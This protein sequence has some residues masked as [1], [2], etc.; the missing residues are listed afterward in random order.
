MTDKEWDNKRTT[1]GVR[2][3]AD[4]R[5]HYKGI[6]WHNGVAFKFS[7]TRQVNGE[8]DYTGRV[9]V[10]SPESGKVLQLTGKARRQRINSYQRKHGNV[11]IDTPHCKQCAVFKDI[12][13]NGDNVDAVK[14]HIEETAKRLFA[15]N[16]VLL[17]SLLRSVCT[18]ET[19]T[20]S[21]AAQ[22]Y[23]EQFIAE[24]GKKI[25]QKTADAHI[26]RLT[27]ACAAL[28][29]RAMKVISQPEIAAA[30]KKDNISNR[31]QR[32]LNRF[33][34]YLLEKGL[35]TGVNPVPS[36]AQQKISTKLLQARAA[37]P[38]VLDLD[39]CDK[40][41]TLIMQHPPSGCD[42]G[43][44]L[45]LWGR[46]PPS[47]GLV[48]GDILFDPGDASLARMRITKSNN[49]G[50][51]HDYTRPLFPQAALILRDRYHSLQSRYKPKKLR[52]MPIISQDTNPAKAMGRNVVLQC[53]N[54]RLR[55]IGVKEETFRCWRAPKSAVSERIMFN[56]YDFLLQNNCGLADDPATVHFLQG[57]PLGDVTSD[58]YTSFTEPAAAKR[59][60]IAQMAVQPLMKI[61][62]PPANT[63]NG[64]ST[65]YFS[66][67]DTRST[68]A[69]DITLCIPPGG[70][71]SVECLNGVSLSAKPR[72]VQNGK[73][74]RKSTSKKGK[75]SQQAS[76]CQGT[77][78]NPGGAVKSAT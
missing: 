48:W 47:E 41:F 34:K 19:I 70:H 53:A 16:A 28:P 32:L 44:A 10:L 55:D 40:L 66:P 37:N 42:C 65:T 3:L 49:A 21:E 60:H 72:L 62:E 20:P 69:A 13:F 52:T 14:S 50:A 25:S 71:V 39:M 23:A 4:G 24:D 27:N 57:K 12:K 46:V 30:V 18:P 75:S 5:E 26:S 7:I 6:Y 11:N 64:I 38:A 43:V 54:K 61:I 31:G 36:N 29:N 51:T 67:P 78:P 59:M 77:E 17:N 56:T 58:H 2:Q 35:C 15:E 9:S 33:W 68:V 76:P 73:P 1:F 45:M 8:Y 22:L 63:D 74:K